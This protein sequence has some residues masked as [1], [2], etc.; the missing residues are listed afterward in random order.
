MEERTEGV[1]DIRTAFQG[2]LRGVASL[3][4]DRALRRLDALIV[5]HDAD[6]L[7]PAG[8]ADAHGPL[9]RRAVRLL[10][11]LP[12]RTSSSC[13]APACCTRCGSIRPAWRGCTCGA[14]GSPG[15]A[16]AGV[17]VPTTSGRRSSGLVKTQMVKNAVIVPG[18]SKGGF[19]CRRHL[20]DP[21]ARFE[22]GRDQYRTLIRGLLDVTDNLTLTGETV[23]P[24]DVV[25]LRRA[26]SLSGGGGRQGDGD[27]LGYGQRGVGRVRVLA[28]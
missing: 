26:R 18:G 4:D 6:E 14:R 13:G 12:P 27:V 16:S 5:G 8:R 25:G 1:A 2:S 21:E 11:V 19:V 15:A 28:R 22:E 10:Q 17:T 20:A 7:L 3:A 24:P 9:G 23:P